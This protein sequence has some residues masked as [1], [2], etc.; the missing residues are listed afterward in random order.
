MILPERQRDKAKE[1]RLRPHQAV[2]PGTRARR[3]Y[4]LLPARC[5]FSAIM[6][7]VTGAVSNPR[8]PERIA[9]GGEP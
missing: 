9:F 3:R 2:T 4:A 6:A 5:R 7:F 8:A 1:R